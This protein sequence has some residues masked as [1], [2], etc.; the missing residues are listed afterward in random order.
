M[1]GH[2]YLKLAFQF[3]F[4]FTVLLILL[5]KCLQLFLEDFLFVLRALFQL[6][7][8]RI[9]VG[10]ICLLSEVWEQPEF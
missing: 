3:Y 7:K 1:Y 4:E 2:V 9:A 10:D 8:S 5:C 6:N